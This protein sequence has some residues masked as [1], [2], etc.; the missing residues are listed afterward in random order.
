MSL[1]AAVDTTRPLSRRNAIL[2]GSWAIVA[3]I[4]AAV[5]GAILDINDGKFV[6]SLDDP[7]IHLALARHI[8]AFHYGINPGEA[9]APASSI[10][11]PFL[12]GLFVPLGIDEFA[13]LILNIAAL[14]VSVLL[15]GAIVSRLPGA[16]AGLTVMLIVLVAFA[17]NLV[18]LAF[19]GL[20]HS[21]HVMLTLGVL[22]G[23]IV[24]AEDRRLPWWLIAAL[25]LGPLVRY[26]GCAVT[27]GGMAALFWLGYRRPPLIAGAL[28][29]LS[30]A[31][32]SAMLWSLGLSPLPSSVLAKSAVAAAGVDGSLAGLAGAMLDT[33]A[34]MPL[35]GMIMG[36]LA[37]A[38][39]FAIV[40]SIS[41]RTN[42]SQVAVGL[43]AVIVAA[44]HLVAGRYNWLY[45]FEI[46]AFATVV[47]AALYVFAP[48]LARR[49]GAARAALAAAVAIAVIGLPYYR[50]LSDTLLSANNIYE[51][52]YQMHRFVHDFYQRPVAVNDLG[53]VAYDSRAYVLDIWGLGYEPARQARFGAQADA[54]AG[55]PRQPWIENLLA[56]RPVGL[57][58]VYDDWFTDMLPPGWTRVARLWRSRQ[59][60]T[61]R[62]SVSFYATNP[63]ALPEI[64]E[65]LDRFG[66]AL[67][68]E[69]RL[70][71]TP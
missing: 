19:T 29:A 47:L 22:A 39:A 21:I 35:S 20:E 68:P 12:L 58:I 63:A 55:R 42:A 17:T 67:P 43:F 46:Y 60:L 23:L 3:A 61:G 14:S 45:R 36:L 59:S 51:Q 6:Y 9:A 38:I 64:T 2:L 30:L 24:T 26:E 32:F 34:A 27:L 31:A 37:A 41:A 33:F 16:P 49:L 11:Y 1:T 15:I 44:G 13:P 57:A 66:R 52:Q 50:A 56:Q 54:L 65:A 10:L 69:I 7:Y 8:A 25:I 62:A 5:L 53:W 28:A 40:P 4:A 70:E 48:A 18:G 71:R